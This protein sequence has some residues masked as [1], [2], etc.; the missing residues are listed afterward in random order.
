MAD[1]FLS[2][3]L[4]ECLYLEYICGLLHG[5]KPMAGQY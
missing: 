4:S 2:Q 1:Q 3:L 5:F